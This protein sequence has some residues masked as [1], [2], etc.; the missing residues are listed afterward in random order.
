M[1]FAL[2]ILSFMVFQGALAQEACSKAKNPVADLK[3]LCD[4]LNK[5]NSSYCNVKTKS[6]RESLP[7]VSYGILSASG[8][9]KSLFEKMSQMQSAFL[10]DSA[11]CPGGCSKVNS[12][13]VEI[14]TKP[15]AVIA[16]AACP[17]AYSSLT[18]NGGELTRFGV[19]QSDGF[20]KKSFKLSGD[21]KKCHEMATKF[22]QDTLMGENDL[23]EYLE[24]QKCKSP[25]SYSSTIRLKTQNL[26]SGC[27]V[28]LELAVQCG[29]PKKDRGWVTTASLTKTFRCEVA[30]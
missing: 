19:G 10:K 4:E 26:A 3:T 6:A 13:V 21:P 23:G 28:D 15:T 24:E 30:Q 7:P 16:D 9:M 5:T 18:L 17:A 14:S 1:K 29:P 11:G 20:L 22:A 2:L 25:C 12:P 8:K 27:A